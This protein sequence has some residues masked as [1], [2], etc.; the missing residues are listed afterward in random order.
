[1]IRP[2]PIGWPAWPHG[3][4]AFR[5]DAPGRAGTLSHYRFR[6]LAQVEVALSRVL[7]SMHSERQLS[8]AETAEMDDVQDSAGVPSASTSLPH[9]CG[10]QK[11]S[12][13]IDWAAGEV[14]HLPSAT[15]AA[16]NLAPGHRIRGGLGKDRASPRSQ[17]VLRIA[18][19]PFL[20]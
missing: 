15:G 19:C 8:T 3:S 6:L 10:Q 18:D 2:S 1:M 17:Q 4:P 13:T 20:V 16:R 7:V 11:W 9:L 5:Q 14:G 12:R